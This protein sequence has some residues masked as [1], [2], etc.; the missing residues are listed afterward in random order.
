LR[1]I[2]L[3]SADVFKAKTNPKRRETLKYKKYLLPDFKVFG[4]NAL[5]LNQFE[6]NPLSAMF[7]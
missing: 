1:N 5:L 4:E 6:L 2:L 3:Y 7:F